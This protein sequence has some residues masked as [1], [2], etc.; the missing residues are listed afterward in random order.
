[1]QNPSILD[2]PDEILLKIF[3]YINTDHLKNTVYDVC[4][5]WRNLTDSDVL[6]TDYSLDINQIC[7]GDLDSL[8]VKIPRFKHFKY[9][10]AGGETDYIVVSVIEHCRFLRT[11]QMPIAN[12]RPE[13][14]ETMME[15]LMYLKDML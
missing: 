13:L 8:L 7:L 2:F 11:F 1:M 15:S 4:K 14:L 12:I 6:W 5:R 3:S 10:V 9:F